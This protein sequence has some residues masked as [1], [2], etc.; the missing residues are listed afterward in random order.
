MKFYDVYY[1]NENTLNIVLHVSV[2]D[3]WRRKDWAK[4]SCRSVRNALPT[5]TVMAVVELLYSTHTHTRKTSVYTRASCTSVHL[6]FTS[7]IRERRE[8]TD[9]VDNLARV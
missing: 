6:G 2:L 7:S 1:V 9:L 3:Y 8:E 4:A 5:T